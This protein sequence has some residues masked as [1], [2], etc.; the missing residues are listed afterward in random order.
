MKIL[1]I[2]GPNLNLIGKREP[3][4]YGGRMLEEI[5][6]ALREQAAQMTVEIDFIQ[7]NH[8]GVLVDAVHKAEEAYDGAVLNAGAYTHTSIALRDAVLAIKKPV[9]EVHF[10]NPAARERFRHSSLL[11]GATVGSIAGFGAESYHLA[12]CWFYRQNDNT[13]K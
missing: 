1:I 10:T 2:N 6:R 13:V 9:I 8:E 4:L 7:S 5:N 11:A 3:G 12:L